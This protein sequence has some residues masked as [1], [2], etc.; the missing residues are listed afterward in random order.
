[1]TTVWSG[2]RAVPFLPSFRN[3]AR[4][5]YQCIMKEWKGLPRRVAFG[6]YHSKPSLDV[7]AF[8]LAP[9]HNDEPS[10]SCFHTPLPS[11]ESPMGKEVSL[12]TAPHTMH[13]RRQFDIRQLSWPIMPLRRLA[14]LFWNSEHLSR[15]HMRH[16]R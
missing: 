16:D 5:L 13:L 14:I 8:W 7:F 11:P 6:R 9:N 10:D 2:A 4:L 3:I 15:S 1:M 12:L